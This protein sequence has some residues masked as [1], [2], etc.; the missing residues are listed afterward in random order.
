MRPAPSGIVLMLFRLTD[1]LQD[2]LVGLAG[3]GQR[4]LRQGL[5]GLQRQQ[6]RRF[7]VHVGQGQVAGTVFEGVDHRIGEGLT[8]LDDREV[9]TEGR[10]LR[11]NI[12]QGSLELGQFSVNVV[13]AV[14]VRFFQSGR[15]AQV[16]RVDSVT[17]C[18]LDVD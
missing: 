7:R 8:V 17:V 10:S 9:R 2:R 13:V 11:T 14:E 15:N 16:G 12:V 5:T 6:V 3:Q 4:V 1:E 18:G